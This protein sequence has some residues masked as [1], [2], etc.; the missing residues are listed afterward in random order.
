MI[1]T[2]SSSRLAH[3]RERGFANGES[4]VGGTPMNKAAILLVI[5]FIITG[6]MTGQ[7]SGAYFP[8]LAFSQ[9]QTRHDAVANWYGKHLRSME[10]P[11]L[12]VGLRSQTNNTTWRFTFLPTF[13]SPTCYRIYVPDSGQGYVIVKRTNGKGGYDTGRLVLREWK[14][15]DCSRVA[16]L[17]R[18]LRDLAFWDLPA[19]GPPEMI[20]LDG[21]K[22][23]LEIAD[24]GEDCN[25]KCRRDG[26]SVPRRGSLPFVV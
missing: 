8:N 6:C 14:P 1:S 16:E 17:Q 13:T 4:G 15:L 26:E 3:P 19:E 5:G 11:S 20:V 21:E 18:L 22:Y 2:T 25:V 23:I 7:R 24:H 12:L 10:E 9:W